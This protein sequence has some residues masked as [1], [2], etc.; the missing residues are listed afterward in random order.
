MTI[1][2]KYDF[3]DIIFHYPMTHCFVRNLAYISWMSDKTIELLNY[4]AI[5]Y[6]NSKSKC[7]R[8]YVGVNKNQIIRYSILGLD[9]DDL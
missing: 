9:Y 7:L 2:N 4:T 3:F 8:R 6:F 5:I 1:F